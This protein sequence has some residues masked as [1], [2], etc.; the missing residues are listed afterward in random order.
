M[1]TTNNDTITQAQSQIGVPQLQPYITA[2]DRVSSL[3]ENEAKLCV[4]YCMLTHK[5]GGLNVFPIMTIY[6]EHIS[7]KSSIMKVMA[8]L[9]NHPVPDITPHL[10]DLKNWGGLKGSDSEPVLRREV[11]FETTAFIEEGD[12][13]YKRKERLVA[14]RFSRQTGTARVMEAQLIGWNKSAIPI[15]GATIIHKRETYRD[16]ATSSRSI[17]IM[18]KQQGDREHSTTI[19]SEEERMQFYNMARSIDI[20]SLPTNTRAHELWYPLIGLATNIDDVAWCDWAIEQVQK[21]AERQTA[22]GDI[23]PQRAVILGILN[24]AVKED[25]DGNLTF[26]ENKYDLPKIKSAVEGNLNTYMSLEQ[27]RQTLE[28]MGFEI[29]KRRGVNRVLVTADKLRQVCVD[30][31]IDDEAVNAIPGG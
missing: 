30:F 8:Q 18:T 1:S 10:P 4:Y 28:L 29:R 2:L 31:G 3:N 9:V 14:D 15:F 6:G 24:V 19:F 27:I 13:L 17:F 20:F 5:I 7:G 22:G 26:Q 21:R 23:D 25:G 12:G 16:P 11:G